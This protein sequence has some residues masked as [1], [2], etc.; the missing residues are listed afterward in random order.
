M[1]ITASFGLLPPEAD[2]H[3]EPAEGPAPL[4]V[5]FTDD[6]TQSPI[7][8]EWDFIGGGAVM[9]TDQNPTHVYKTAGYYTV[10]L[11]AYYAGGSDSETK[12]SYI[13]AAADCS[14]GPVR[15]GGSDQPTLQG[16]YGAAA[17]GAVI[18]AHAVDFSE[19]LDL[20]EDKTVTFDW[21][22]NCD[23]SDSIHEGG[24]NGTLTIRRGTL[25]IAS[26]TIIGM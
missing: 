9:S 11:T 17:D 2:F 3:G 18:Y 4:I 10:S 15:T 25:M 26:K 5:R 24:F 13:H 20:D 23:F 7:A 16:G 22:W 19:N 21:G 1:T 6:S 8:W 12:P 14:A